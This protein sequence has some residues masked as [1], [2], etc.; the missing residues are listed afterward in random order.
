MWLERGLFLQ[1]SLPYCYGEKKAKSCIELW[2][3]SLLFLHTMNNFA[4]ST[5]WG[6]KKPM[7]AWRDLFYFG[8]KTAQHVKSTQ[9][10]NIPFL[11]WFKNYFSILWSFYS[12]TRGA[13][14]R[15]RKAYILFLPLYVH[16]WQYTWLKQE[17]ILSQL[18]CVSCDGYSPFCSDHKCKHWLRQRSWFVFFF[19]LFYTSVVLHPFLLCLQIQGHF[20]FFKLFLH[21][22]VFPWPC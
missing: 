3:V 8:H 10:Y 12:F 13:C 22:V 4:N 1:I 6:I 18:L 9:N 19:F 14:L 7:V 20:D 15:A 2:G 5:E 16:T 11:R 17:R 21:A